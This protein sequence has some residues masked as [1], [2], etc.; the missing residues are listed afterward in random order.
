MSVLVFQH[1]QP[2]EAGVQVPFLPDPGT[3]QLAQPHIWVSPVRVQQSASRAVSRMDARAAAYKFCRHLPD[4]HPVEGRARNGLAIR[5]VQRCTPARTATPPASVRELLGQT[6]QIPDVQ[7]QAKVSGSSNVHYGRVPMAGRTGLASKDGGAAGYSLVPYA[8]QWCRA[9]HDN[10]EPGC[11]GTLVH[12]DPRR[13]GNYSSSGVGLCSGNRCRHNISCHAFNGGENHQ[14]Q[15][16]TAR[17]SAT[18]ARTTSLVP[19]TKR[20]RKLGKSPMQGRPSICSDC[21]P[22][23]RLPAQ[24]IHEGHSREPNGGNRGFVCPQHDPQ[25]RAGAGH[26]RCF[27]VEVSQAA[28]IQGGLVWTNGYCY[29]S[30]LPEFQNMLGV[31]CDCCDD[32]PKHPGVGV[33]QLW[34]TSRPGRE[35]SEGNFGGRTGRCCLRRW[36]KTCPRVA[37]GGSR[38]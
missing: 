4:A 33:R 14:P 21:R 19:Q 11:G 31:R 13:G 6:G 28:G 1:G 15:A 37:L 34:R 23:L 8:P 16:R 38:Q 36:C 10:G 9:I 18:G 27:L 35:R 26:L 22:T 29:R 17:P 12:L 2:G 20:K 7:V 24:T 32:A 30:V 3:S 25:S 5:G